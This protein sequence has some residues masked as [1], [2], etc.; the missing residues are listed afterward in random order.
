MSI[1]QCV[2]GTVGTSY[3]QC[4]ERLH[5]GDAFAV[6]A[7][8]LMRSRYSALVKKQVDYIVSTTAKGQQSFLDVPALEAWSQSTHWSHLEVLTH[9]LVKDRRHASVEFKAYFYQE[10]QLQVH[11]E[12]SFFVQTDDCWYFLDPT[13]EQTYTMKQACICGSGKKFKNCCCSFLI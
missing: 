13:V 3:A 4:C 12:Q 8:Q 9:Q 10:E 7:E 11:H 6:T 2:C 5:R 1:L